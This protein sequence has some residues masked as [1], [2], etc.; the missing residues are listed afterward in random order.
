MCV[1]Y[2]CTISVF[3]LNTLS[4]SVFV[5]PSQSAV[6]NRA[7]VNGFYNVFSFCSFMLAQ[8]QLYLTAKLLKTS[9]QNITIT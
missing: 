7:C 4:L 8:L 9:A 5:D 3:S 6:Y 1:V 2:Q